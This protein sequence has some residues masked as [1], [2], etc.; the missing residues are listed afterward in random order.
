M[1]TAAEYTAWFDLRSRALYASHESC[2]QAY[3]SDGA[4][5]S[6]GDD[7]R[8]I[9]SLVI[10]LPGNIVEHSGHIVWQ[11]LKMFGEVGIDFGP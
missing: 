10:Y 3:A 11:G 8:M 1:G 4:G 5:D 2:G 6:E 7:A 9:S